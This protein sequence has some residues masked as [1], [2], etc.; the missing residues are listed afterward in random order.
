MSMTVRRSLFAAGLLLTVTPPARAQDAPRGYAVQSHTPPGFR[1]PDGAGCSGEV[2]RWR[3]VQGNDYA[4]GNVSLKVYGQIQ[5][6]IDRAAAACEAGQDAQARR[7][8][9]DSKRRH[10]YPP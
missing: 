5:A 4:G 2:A 9:A 10:G 1:M 3:A 6:E 7:M 8:V